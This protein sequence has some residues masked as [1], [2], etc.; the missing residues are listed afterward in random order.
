MARILWFLSYVRF[1]FAVLFFL[2]HTLWLSFLIVFF[3]NSRRL[4]QW[5][6]IVWSRGILWVFGVK[7]ALEG[8][9]NL[10]RAG[11]L[12]FHHTSWFD[13]WVLHA[14]ITQISRFGAKAELFKI[15]IFSTAMRV[16]GV[17]PIAREKRA[18]VL[19]V[20]KE[21]ESRFADGESFYL[22]PEGTRQPAG[23]GDELPEIGP[24]KKGPFIFAHGAGV[25]VVPIYMAG[26]HRVMPKKSF[27]AGCGRWHTSVLVRVLPPLE[28]APLGEGDLPGLMTEVRSQLRAAREECWGRY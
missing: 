12:L 2:V 22:A 28:T 16:A 3:Q 11:V 6:C 27:L 14:C 9:E 24:F 15:P 4:Q 25:P 21:A 26:V 19:A 7:V 18:E 23:P 1:P 5:V 13:I 20:Y 8:A 17:L 10:P